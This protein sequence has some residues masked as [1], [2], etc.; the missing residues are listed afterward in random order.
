MGE[1]KKEN[2]MEEIRDLMGIPRQS[3]LEK[4]TKQTLIDRIREKTSNIKQPDNPYTI[5]LWEDY[6]KDVDR[7]VAAINENTDIGLFEIDAAFGGLNAV[8]K[9]RADKKRKELYDSMDAKLGLDHSTEEKNPSLDELQKS[10]DEYLCWLE[11]NCFST[12]MISRI[13]FPIITAKEK[14]GFSIGMK[15]EGTE[16]VF[17]TVDSEDIQCTGY[18]AKSLE[19]LLG[20][21]EEFDSFLQS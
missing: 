17:E 12:N 10:M 16:E 1:I 3:E 8:Y 15:G 7:F 6:L 2:L 9:I 4:I 5:A 21:Y 13:A 19:M 20:E 11:L 18:Q 14:L